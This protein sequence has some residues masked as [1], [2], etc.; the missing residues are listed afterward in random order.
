MCIPPACN[1]TPLPH[2]THTHTHT[3]KACACLLPATPLLCLTPPHTPHTHTLPSAP[4]GWLRM[5]MT[6]PDPESHGLHAINKRNKSSPAISIY[7][8]LFDKVASFQQLTLKKKKDNE[9]SETFA[10]SVYLCQKLQ[11]HSQG[12]L[13]KLVLLRE[14]GR[15]EWFKF[16][17]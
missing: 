10:H 6:L 5:E 1:P 14:G 15:V 9:K 17:I 13:G 16:S 3:D 4:E 8:C 2:L 12:F 11:K 7:C